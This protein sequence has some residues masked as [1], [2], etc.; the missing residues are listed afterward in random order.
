MPWDHSFVDPRVNQLTAHPSL[1]FV[2]EL[3]K[4]GRLRQSTESRDDHSHEELV[5]LESRTGYVEVYQLEM[6][7]SCGWLVL[8]LNQ[9]PALGQAVL[10]HGNMPVS[11]TVA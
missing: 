11:P 4:T 3:S 10:Q 2:K 8:G 6:I 7:D 9:G 1:E 5:C